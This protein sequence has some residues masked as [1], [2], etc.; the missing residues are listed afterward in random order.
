[1]PRLAQDLDRA[2]GDGSYSG[3]LSKLARADL[4]ILDD[5]GLAPLTAAEGRDLLEVID[6]R[7]MLRSTVVASQLPLELWHGVVAD[8]A[9]ADAILDRLVQN[10]HKIFLT[11]ES[12]RKAMAGDTSNEQ[13]DSH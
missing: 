8:P 4:V 13:G 12:M 1:M 2:K 3:T 11:G 6:D 5:W 9:V 7:S 10:A